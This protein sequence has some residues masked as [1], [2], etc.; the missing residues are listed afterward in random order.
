[1]K[2]LSQTFDVMIEKKAILIVHEVLVDRLETRYRLSGIGNDSK[3][4][5][6]NSIKDAISNK[7]CEMVREKTEELSN[8]A[9]LEDFVKKKITSFAEH[10]Y[11]RIVDDKV[12]VAIDDCIREAI[13]EGG[14]FEEIVDR[15]NKLQLKDK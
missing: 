6:L 2:R 14:L 13:S 5:Y 4:E 9:V 12:K 11:I 3:K 1:M 15:V 10:Q 7:L 8:T